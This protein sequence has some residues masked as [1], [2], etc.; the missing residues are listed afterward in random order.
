MTSW[1]DY[2]PLMARA[3]EPGRQRTSIDLIVTQAPKRSATQARYFSLSLNCFLNFSTFGLITYWQY[4]A[5]GLRA[6]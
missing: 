6:K 5:S 1:E 3:G 4:P 2:W